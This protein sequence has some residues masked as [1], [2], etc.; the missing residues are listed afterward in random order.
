[1]INKILPCVIGL[2]YVGLPV[3]IRLNKKFST[4]GFDINKKTHKED[5]V[6]YLTNIPPVVKHKCKTIL[7]QSN[8]FVIDYFPLSGFSLITKIRINVERLLFKV[9]II[10]PKVHLT[11]FL[12]FSTISKIKFEK[13]RLIKSN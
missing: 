7:V 3:F 10:E 1:M 5:I 11:N 2:G 13:Y 9:N 4:T 12:F 6:I 8:R